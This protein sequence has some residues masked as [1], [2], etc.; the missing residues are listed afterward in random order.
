MKLFRHWMGLAG[1]LLLPVLNSRA[2]APELA[3]ELVNGNVRLQWTNNPP[4]FRLESRAALNLTEDWQ[5]VVMATVLGADNRNTVTLP[6]SGL[7][8]FFR[9]G[10]TPLT[11][12]AES[13]PANGEIGVGVMRETILRFSTP[14]ATN[15]L[16]SADNFFA[17]YQG[18]RLLSRIE[19]GN[20]RRTATLFYLEPLPA[21][22]LVTAVFDGTGLTDEMGRALDPD[23]DGHPGGMATVTFQTFGSTP[24][25]GTAV[26][27]HVYASELM[28]GMDNAS[29]TN[30]P[31]AGVTITVD[32]Q[33]QTLRTVTDA[34]GFFSLTPCP[35]GRFFVK[36]DGRTAAGSQYPSGAYYP[37][38]GKP[39][40]AIAGKTNNLAG[41]TGEIFLPK[42]AKG[43]LTQI[44][45]LTNTTITFPA[46]VISSNPAL[47][48]VSVMVPANSLYSNDGTR[49]GRVGIAPVSPDRLPAPLPPGL[50]PTL[51]ITIQTD[52]ANNFDRPVPVRFPNLP[53][54]R[55]GNLLPPGG[56]S[57]LWSFNHKTGRWEI[58]GAMTVSADGKFLETDPGVGVRQPGWG[59]PS[60]GTD[61]SGGGAGGP[62]PNNPNNPNDPNNPGNPSDPKDPCKQARKSAESN[63]IQCG[64][65]IGFAVLLTV[66]EATP[67][68]GC[69]IA[70]AQGVIGSVADCNID[71]STCGMTILNNVANTAIGCL[72][73]L[74]PAFNSVST[75]GGVYKSCLIDANKAASELAL[76]ELQH[77]NSGGASPR[78]GHPRPAGPDIAANVYAEQ[79]ALLE[80]AADLHGLVF[81]NVKWTEVAPE[82]TAML[83]RFLTALQV[84]RDP[85]SPGGLR[86]TPEEQA[87]LLQL[88]LPSNISIADATALLSRFDR[89]AAGLLAPGEFDQGAILVAAQRLL[90]VAQTLEDRGWITTYDACFRGITDPF[91]EEGKAQSQLPPYQKPLAYRLVNLSVGGARQYGHLNLLGQFDNLPL[92]ANSYYQLDY[93]DRDTLAVGH[94]V[95]RSA[96]NGVT[97]KIPRAAMN[98]P[99]P[100][101]SDHDG[102]P[103]EV[104]NVL[105]TNPHQADTDGDGVSDGAEVTAGTDPLDGS[106][107]LP[108][109]IGSAPATGPAL[110]VAVHGN[111]ALVAEGDSGLGIYNVTTAQPSLVARLNLGTVNAVAFAGNSGLATVG[112]TGL[113]IIDLSDPVQPTVSRIIGLGATA[114]LGG[115]AAAG[116]LAYVI[117]DDAL[118]LVDLVAGGLLDQRSLSPLIQQDTPQDIAVSGSSVYLL[119]GQITASPGR[120]YLHRFPIG[121][122][123]EADTASLL[124]AGPTYRIY[125]RTRLALAPGYVYITGMD[126]LPPVLSSSLTIISDGPAGLQV[127]APQANYP[128]F[129]A[130]ATGSGAVLAGGA[131]LLLLDVRDP[132]SAV[133]V[134]GTISLPARPS[135][136]ALDQGRAYVAYGPF[137]GSGG[138]AVVSY[139]GADTLGQPPTISLAAS[140]PFS[141]AIVEPN[142]PV[143]VTA[144]AVDDFQV[145]NVEFYLNGVLAETVGAYPFDFRFKT[146]ATT[147]ETAF[148]I[149]ARAFDTGGNVTT[150]DDITVLVKAGSPPP[151][152]TSTL[153]LPKAVLPPGLTVIQAGFD[154]ALAPA[155]VTAT[156]VQLVSAGADGLLDTADDQAVDAAASYDPAHQSVLLTPVAPLLGGSYR[157]TLG[158]GVA[159]THGI[160]L[161]APFSWTFSLKPPVTWEADAAGAWLT[162]GNW[163]SNT[164]PVMGDFVL[165]DRTNG[166]YTVSYNG[167]NLNLDSLLSREPVV[168][169]GGKF[170]VARR[171]RIEN[172]LTLNAATLLVSPDAELDVTGGFNWQTGTLD[173]GGT[174]VVDG[175]LSLSGTPCR[176]LQHTLVSRGHTTWNEPNNTGILVD[177]PAAVLHNAEG[178]IWEAYDRQIMIYTGFQGAARFENDGL[179]RAFGNDG[180]INFTQVMFN[181]HGTASVETGSLKLNGGGTSDGA[182]EIAAP[183]TLQLGGSHVLTAS[184]SLHGSGRVQFATGNIIVN[185]RYDVTGVTQF[186]GVPGASA[187][188]VT[189]NGPILNL[190]NPLLLGNGSRATFLSPDLNFT[191]VVVDGGILDFSQGPGLV[192]ARSLTLTNFAFLLGS[193][194]VEVRESLVLQGALL[195]GPGRLTVHGSSLLLGGQL[196]TS[197]GNGKQYPRLFYNAG[198]AV[199]GRDLTIASE[200]HNLAGATF[201][202]QGDYGVLEG[203]NVGPS[204]FI[205]AGALRK[206]QGTGNGRVSVAL[207]NTGLIEVLTGKLQVGDFTQTAGETRL[208][209]VAIAGF[210]KFDLQGGSLTGTGNLEIYP[211]KNIGAVVSPGLPEA[212]IGMFHLT[213]MYTQSPAGTLALDLAGPTPGTGFD[214]LNIDNEAKLDGTLRVTFVPA[215]QPVLGGTYR[216]LTASQ[217][218]GKFA[219]V[220]TTGLPT[221]LKAALTY[222]ST[223]VTLTVVPGP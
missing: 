76:C 19:L 177:D 83:V 4:G 43:T 143:V 170:S 160:H 186:G 55:S 193:G 181:N 179:F 142:T 67:G 133:P 221:G 130:A 121:R 140:F 151:S 51:V 27:G 86:L 103:D 68:V 174:T 37:F 35:A 97:T 21:G 182:F 6:P 78:R 122:R 33:E 206:S 184:A 92:E 100:Q 209:G 154:H 7:D 207:R 126:A 17:G 150:T 64:V 62:D 14:L 81:G 42:I 48:G 24:L 101:D 26:I 171:S 36:I 202:I 56:K 84:A 132:Q 28:P 65:G 93:L 49:G 127:A 194:D 61:G 120:N 204:A 205:N 34:N 164:L 210:G 134:L 71:S 118:Y 123:L 115:I 70:A 52:G 165:I 111:Y 108:G 128:V 15:T 18:R 185:G 192:T 75:Y 91:T 197:V 79:I 152:V 180:G 189:F 211:F 155:S 54:R 145:Q 85:S 199:L 219:T 82:E 178:G 88:P 58:Q 13:S 22:A 218:S 200:L 94:T 137:E 105:G 198:S 144:Q 32:G 215:Y 59:I 44:S 114:D 109:V 196:F 31:L 57:A 183:A 90:A 116:D 20:D 169:G 23:G 11:T 188:S 139:F 119:T 69:A 73:L 129:S 40:E 106:A 95:F 163:I 159:D 149:K 1:L 203:S 125:A 223:G 157:V 25:T 113:A 166:T 156:T 30:R 99:D 72:P 3:V 16:F 147:N 168:I 45:P 104:E 107:Q 148:T 89:A 8:R 53:D 47:A 158:A 2:Q 124:L 187:V 66:A 217:C 214:Q 131:S 190:G 5:S 138:L 80:A 12:I 112:R 29:T 195:G 172:S 117:S 96:D 63:A 110:R 60:P 213:G 161:A 46:S 38:V 87:A 216:I 50:D 41:G 153:P 212:P 9:L 220:I 98:P 167:G 135:D 10:P 191:N 77:S 39:W 102:L 176:M 208:A 175:E 222:D 74:G 141:P 136:I 173:G 162:P 201:D 146:P